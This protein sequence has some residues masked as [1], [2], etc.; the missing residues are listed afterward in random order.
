MKVQFYCNS[1]ANIHSKR[2]ETFD[3]Q[4]DLGLEDGEWEALTV[5]EKD[6]MVEEWMWERLEYGYRELP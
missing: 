6:K 3:T 5:E 1:G 2:E 4:S